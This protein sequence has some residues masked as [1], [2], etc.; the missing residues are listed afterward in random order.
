M[1]VRSVDASSA[2]ISILTAMLVGRDLEA[3]LLASLLRAAES[4]TGKVGV[5]AGIAGIGKSALIEAVVDGALERSFSVRQVR[6]EP[7]QQ[8]LP[9]AAVRLLLKDGSG[10][11]QIKLLALLNA[12]SESLESSVPVSTVALGLLAFFTEVS[13]D[14]PL[15]VA[16]DDAQWIDRRVWQ[17]FDSWRVDYW[18]IAL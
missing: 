12:E 15:L 7:T 4:G 8:T 9:Y 2:V 17:C 5:V 1:S 18:P 16:I 11:A 14:A 6:G 13:T 3:E 10:P